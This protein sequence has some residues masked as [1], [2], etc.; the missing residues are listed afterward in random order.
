MTLLV[1][2]GN[3]KESPTSKKYRKAPF[4]T[5]APFKLWCRLFWLYRCVDQVE[6]VLDVGALVLV[7][8]GR[9][10]SLDRDAALSLHPKLVKDLK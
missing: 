2:G 6:E 1:L 5:L 10:L 9:R 7:D 8:D 3:K 4:V